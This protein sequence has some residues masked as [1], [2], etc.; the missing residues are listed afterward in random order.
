MNDVSMSRGAI[1]FEVRG[2]N[3]VR[4][5]L[6]TIAAFY[7]RKVD[8]VAQVDL[9][10]IRRMLKAKPYPAKRPG[11]KY[12]RTG[13][14]ANKWAV[15]RVKPGLWRIVNNASLRGRV[16]AGY[17]VGNRQA[18]MHKNRWWIASEE[19]DREM[20]AFTQALSTELEKE[21]R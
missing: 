17:V 11:Q 3:R 14:L 2:I 18:W 7:P 4:N 1:S 5:Q 10:R 9:Q 13:L 15:E 8:D 16:Y 6:R 20:L 19:I 21:L 12:V